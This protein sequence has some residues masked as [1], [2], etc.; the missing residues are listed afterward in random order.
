MSS[1][2]VNSLYNRQNGKYP[3]QLHAANSLEGCVFI[4]RGVL[5]SYSGVVKEQLTSD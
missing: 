5:H 1:Q 4:E 3:A 2:Q